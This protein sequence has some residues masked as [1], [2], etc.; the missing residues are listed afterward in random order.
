MVTV[1][2]GEVSIPTLRWLIV[3]VYSQ[4]PLLAKDLVSADEVAQSLRYRR[5]C[6]LSG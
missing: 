5:G 1:M 4:L 6:Q 2:I 3:N